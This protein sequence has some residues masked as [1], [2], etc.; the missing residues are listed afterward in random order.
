MLQKKATLL[1]LKNAAK[2]IFSL[3][4]LEKVKS[5]ISYVFIT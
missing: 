4:W 5:V 1:S 2:T 3:R